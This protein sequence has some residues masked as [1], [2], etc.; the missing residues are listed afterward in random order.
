MWWRNLKHQEYQQDLNPVYLLVFGL[1]RHSNIAFSVRQ[2]LVYFYVFLPSL[3]DLDSI[4][5]PSQW[6]W[7][8]DWAAA[9][10]LLHVLLETASRGEALDAKT[11]T[12]SV[13][14]YNA[15]ISACERSSK[16]TWALQLLQDIS[17]RNLQPDTITFNTCISACSNALKWQRAVWLFHQIHLQTLAPTGVTFSALVTAFEKTNDW[18]RA[19]VAFERALVMNA[20][21]VVTFNS[22]ITACDKG[23]QWERALGLLD[24]MHWHSIKADIFSW[25]STMSACCRAQRWQ[26][27]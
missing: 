3:W 18:I 1:V 24:A 6:C 19:L 8:R 20:A 4:F 7:G 15:T 9:V 22:I 26:V 21:S 12:I 27:L 17:S 10:Q 25:N 23:Q 11:T 16:W 14:S 2:N 5:I 13:I